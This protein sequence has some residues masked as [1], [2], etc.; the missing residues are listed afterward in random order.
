MMPGLPIS[1]IP[2][3]KYNRQGGA[4]LEFFQAMGRFKPTFI[5][6]NQAFKMIWK[7]WWL[8]SRIKTHSF[9]EQIKTS[10]NGQFKDFESDRAARITKLGNRI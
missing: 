5:E 1:S 4:C 2:H 9:L 7:V 3:C 8:K 10:S 6:T